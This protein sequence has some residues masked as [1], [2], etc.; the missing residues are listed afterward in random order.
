MNIGPFFS[1]DAIGL[2]LAAD[3]QFLET[4]SALDT[5]WQLET[6]ECAPISL[7]STLGLQARSFQIMPQVSLNKLS[8]ERIQDF[9]CQPCIELI[10]SNYVRLSVT[11][12]SDVKALIEFWVRSGDWVQGRIS[13][14]NHGESNIEAGARLA[15]RLITL[16]GNSELKPTR[17]GFQ[18]NLKGQTGSLS[19]HLMLDGNSKTVLSPNL[20]L[21]QSKHLSPGQSLQSL[22]Q[23][24]IQKS[25][26]EALPDVRKFPVNWDGEIARLEI[27]NQSRMVQITTPQS[28]WD[29][30][31]YSNQNQ[32]FQLLRKDAQGCI[33]PDKSRSI[34]SA[35]SPINGNTHT[36]ISALEL[37]QLTLSLLP[38][39]VEDAAKLLADYLLRASTNLTKNPQAALPFPCLCDLAWR[40]HQQ[41]QQKDYLLEIYPSL[42]AVCLA[43]FS[44][45][46][47]CDQDG[48]PEWTSVEQCG[49][50]SLPVFDLVD[51][52]NMATRINYTEQLNLAALLAIELRELRKAAQVADDQ[53][54]L[55][56]IDNH[57]AI[58]DAFIASF[59][60]KDYQTGCVDRDSHRWHPGEVLFQGD[61]KVFGSKSIYLSQPA[62]LNFKLRPSVQ[63]RKP[64]VFYLHGENA[65]A[66][67]VVEPVEPSNLLWL[68]GGFFFT[69][70]QMYTRIDKISDLQ[71]EEC[72]LQIHQANLISHDLGILLAT[73][74]EKEQ[75]DAENEINNNWCLKPILAASNYGLPENLDPQEGKKVVNLSWNL[76]ILAEL[77]RKGEAEAALQ[78]LGQLQQAQINHLCMEH[79]NTDR[80][81]SQNGRSFGLRNTIGGLIPVNLVLELAGIRIINE[82]RVTL[83][84]QN[85]FPWLFKV[86]FR[87][88]EVTRDG[89][90]TTVRFPDGSVQHHFGSSQKTFT[91]EIEKKA[92]S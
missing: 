33:S 85:P 46:H 52:D 58:L 1:R 71:I 45:E 14:T 41:Y 67:Q 42:K 57:L 61:L 43:W 73:P 10:F 77:I 29:A 70:N 87:G 81:S 76:L 90:N 91:S 47:D 3:Q 53:I 83:F 80:W 56:T 16:Q 86:Q 36:S 62:R 92:T 20:A 37:W 78:L 35:F 23:C 19:V 84:G 48:L 55:T 31:F 5:V 40:V 51:N 38:A 28:N 26:G 65:A 17:H 79:S 30:V 18:T 54:T 44:P 2:T 88:L 21:E 7:L 11:P 27:A 9:F 39:Q 72:Y 49:L 22:W 66:K 82:N 64:P 74:I 63:L 4:P 60:N 15:A 13:I 8:R 50:S 75:K 12:F 68:P 24:E 32:A 25:G 34:H 6:E 59:A 69:T 89:K